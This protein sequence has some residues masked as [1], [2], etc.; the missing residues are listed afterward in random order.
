VRAYVE[1]VRSGYNKTGLANI[2]WRHG[3]WVPPP[4]NN[5]TDEHLTSLFAFLHDV[6]LLRNMSRRLEKPI[7]TS[8]YSTLYDQLTEEF[9]RVFFNTT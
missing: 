4:P 7:D 3:D 2:F 6:L 9:H 8:I 5:R 1:A